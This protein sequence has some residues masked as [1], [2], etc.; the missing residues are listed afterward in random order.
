MGCIPIKN[1]RLSQ[2]NASLNEVFVQST[3]EAVKIYEE[4]GGKLSTNLSF[5]WNPLVM[6]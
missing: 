1:M 2:Q 3:S 4:L 6:N 5:D